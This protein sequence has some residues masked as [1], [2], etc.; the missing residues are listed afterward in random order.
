MVIWLG[1]HWL[2][3][4]RRFIDLELPIYRVWTGLHIAWTA[5]A[6][7]GLLISLYL[8]S[9]VFA[10]AGQIGTPANL[11]LVLWI[12]VFST[13]LNLLATVGWA[14]IVIAVPAPQKQSSLQ[15]PAVSA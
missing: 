5:L 3:I 12:S 8:L 11:K 2:L 14:I 10:L 13:V 15:S 9:I 4:W 6:L 7:L 1:V